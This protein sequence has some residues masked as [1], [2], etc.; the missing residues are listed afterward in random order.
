MQ[1]P[2]FSLQ[3]ACCLIASILLIVF[4]SYYAVPPLVDFQGHVA[5]GMINSSFL[6]Q[7]YHYEFSIIYHLF[8]SIVRF[9]TFFLG[10]NYTLVSLACYFT[11]IFLIFSTVYISLILQNVSTKRAFY[12]LAILACPMFLLLHCGGFMWGV[13]PY[14][15]AVFMAVAS[16]ISLW[17]IHQEIIE[18]KTCSHQT[19][20]IFGIYTFLAIYSHSVGFLYLG[21]SWVIPL[22]HIILT[23][24]YG[25]KRF[26]FI[27][28]LSIILLV[29]ALFLKL[30]FVNFAD[31]I[32]EI[33][34]RL[35]WIVSGTPY[36][37]SNL[38]PHTQEGWFDYKFFRI[39]LTFIPY[40]TAGLLIYFR[41]KGDEWSWLLSSQLIFQ[42]ILEIFIVNSFGNHTGNLLYLHSRNWLFIDAWTFLG[43]AYL[44]NQCRNKI[45]KRLCYVAPLLAAFCLYAVAPF[46][47]NF[48][49]VPIEKQANHYTKI[50]V[51]EVAQYRNKHPEIAKKTIVITYEHHPIDSDWFLYHL[52]PTL[53]INSPLLAKNNIVIQSHWCKLYFAPLKWELPSNQKVVYLHWE[54]ETKTYVKLKAQNS[55]E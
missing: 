39:L 37:S 16:S 18:K 48:R 3:T 29:L 41:K 23:K 51:N 46:Y 38:I 15:L 7:Y 25:K 1:H 54:S 47:E 8:D 19:L 50:L 4:I 53:M 44:V 6:S 14:S 32:N 2:K 52:I 34:I 22:V 5:L 33:S 20:I 11:L 27:I 43:M 24:Q 26:L 49:S 55:I 13:I 45:F 42:F 28:V 36:N 9:W 12:I 30:P 21:I 35:Q 17:K 31:W 10:N 40:I